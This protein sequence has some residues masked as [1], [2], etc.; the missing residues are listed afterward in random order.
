[1]NQFQDIPRREEK[2]KK[3]YDDVHAVFPAKL[4]SFPL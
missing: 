1:M 4:T 3:W 2:D